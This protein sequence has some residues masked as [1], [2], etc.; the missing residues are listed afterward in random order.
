[1]YDDYLKTQEQVESVLLAGS[2][3]TLSS[4]GTASTASSLSSGMSSSSSS[5]SSLMTVSKLYIV[6]DAYYLW[7]SRPHIVIDAYHL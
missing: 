6:I 3:S 4:N 2:R 5:N 1:M 7:Q